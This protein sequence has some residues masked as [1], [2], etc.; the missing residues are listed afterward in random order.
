[1][2]FNRGLFTKLNLV[3]FFVT[4]LI[5]VLLMQ[6]KIKIKMPDFIIPSFNYHKKH[7]EFDLPL[8][9]HGKTCE[10][11]TTDENRRK[12]CSSCIIKVQIGNRVL[13]SLI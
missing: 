6:E 12:E 1:M 2:E 8:W 4:C 10:A 3:L 13:H 7:F 5:I 11:K 9:I